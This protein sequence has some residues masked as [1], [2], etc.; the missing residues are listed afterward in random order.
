MGKCYHLRLLQFPTQLQRK[1]S[2][3]ASE[4]AAAIVGAEVP[5]IGGPC[6]YSERGSQ[7]HHQYNRSYVERHNSHNGRFTSFDDLVGVGDGRQTGS[8]EVAP[9]SPRAGGK[10]R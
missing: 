4:L 10:A 3:E 9:S 7:N 8:S 5:V 1:N 2:R 6:A